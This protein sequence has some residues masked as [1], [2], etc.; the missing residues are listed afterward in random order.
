MFISEWD[1]WIWICPICD[2]TGRLATA[3]EIEKYEKE[4]A[5]KWNSISMSS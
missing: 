5:E 3:A 1:G 4:K 2:K